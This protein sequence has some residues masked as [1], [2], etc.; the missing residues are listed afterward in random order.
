MLKQ[1]LQAKM[2]K[3]NQKLLLIKW[4]NQQFKNLLP[5]KRKKKLPKVPITQIKWPSP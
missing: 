5:I 2:K 1:Q 3:K 4:L